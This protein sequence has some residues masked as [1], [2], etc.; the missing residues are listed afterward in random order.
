MTKDTRIK[1]TDTD[2]YMCYAM[3]QQALPDL[4]KHSMLK[5]SHLDFLEFLELIG[6]VADCHL[7]EED[8]E[9]YEKINRV[10]DEWL[11]IVGESRREPV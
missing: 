6:R 5:I 8:S 3:S 7:G 1:L 2:A 4:V 9:L 11:G 10:L